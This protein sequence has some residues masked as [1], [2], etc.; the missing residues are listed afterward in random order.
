M[1]QGG[2]RPG[3][4]IA[5]TARRGWV[6]LLLSGLV[7]AVLSAAVPAGPAGLD[8]LDAAVRST[9][10]PSLE[11]VIHLVNV[12]GSLP[13][14]LLALAAFAILGVA[15]RWPR[16]DGLAVAGMAEIANIAI[17]VAV[18]RPRPPGAESSDFLVAAGFPSGHVTRT[19]VLIGV[20]LVVVPVAARHP[21]A[22]IILGVVATLLM[23]LSRVASGEHY[24][25]DV[26]GGI[27]LAAVLLSAWAIALSRLNPAGDD[28]RPAADGAARA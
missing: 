9:A 8:E 25:S 26:I 18:G 10:L 12:A 16:L 4:G 6:I 15:H 3:P 27:L 2:L 28:A 11:P 1:R 19:A 21:R 22:T 14:W 24:A 5:A 23:S 20:V 17:K 13:V 7:L